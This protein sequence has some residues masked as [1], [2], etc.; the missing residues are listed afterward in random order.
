[1]QENTTTV[2]KVARP[3]SSTFA[4]S[5]SAT[6][7]SAAKFAEARRNRPALPQTARTETG[8]VVAIK[9]AAPGLLLIGVAIAEAIFVEPIR[10]IRRKLR[11]NARRVAA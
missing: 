6:A 8:A 10:S 2:R 3:A 9:D 7:R 11:G 1:M 5:T 4:G